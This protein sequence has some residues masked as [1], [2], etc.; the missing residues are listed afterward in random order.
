MCMVLI[1][2][3]CVCVCLLIA[4]S[5]FRLHNIFSV[6]LAVSGIACSLVS[7][8]LCNSCHFERVI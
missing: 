4:G 3:V 6:V 5:L 2:G 8:P 7:V 1:L